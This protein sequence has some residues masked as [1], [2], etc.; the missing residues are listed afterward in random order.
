VQLLHV[1]RVTAIMENSSDIFV[2]INNAVLDLQGAHAQS[3]ER[4]LKT[5]ARLLR[6]PDLESANNALTKEVD[7]DAFLAES[8]KTQGGMTGSASLVWPESHEKILGLT[9]LLIFKFADEVDYI[10]NFGHTFF[11]SGAQIISGVHAVTGQLIIPFIRDYKAYVLNHGNI[12]PRLM[13]STSK[14]VFIVHGHDGEARETV[15]RFLANIGFDPIILHEQANRGRTVIEKVEANSDVGFAVVLLTPDDEG[16][17]KG[18]KSEPRARQNVLLEL[19]YFIGRLGREKVCALKRGEVEIPSDFAGV[20]WEIMDST[21]GWKQVL[22][23][24]LQ[25]AGHEID[26]NKV[27]R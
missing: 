15:A 5:L 3:Y 13:V 1:W 2:Q 23:R 12:R 16:C 10:V 7:I 25:A 21:N 18:G 4:P 24:E 9:I 26:W 17:Q 11:Y 19:G 14:K 27:M 20:V 6:E 8:E 22:G